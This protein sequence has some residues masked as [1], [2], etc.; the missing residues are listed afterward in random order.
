MTPTTRRCS[1]G[2]ALEGSIALDNM[3]WEGDVLDPE[4]D[5]GKAI[6]AL[7]R[8]IAMDPRVE[9]VLLTV[10]DGIMLVRKN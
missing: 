3:L 1:S 4:D 6:D 5:D 9:A 7:N 10:R 2:S 8:K